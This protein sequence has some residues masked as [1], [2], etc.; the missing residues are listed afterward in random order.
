MPIAKHVDWREFLK[1][2]WLLWDTCAVINVI[3]YD[4]DELFSQLK[5]NGV[6]NVYIHP[7]QLELLATSDAK[8]AIKRADIL[9]KELELLPFTVNELKTAKNLQVAISTGSTSPPQAMD[10]YVGATLAN[11]NPEKMCLI[12]HNI[13]HFPS[14]Y[15]KQECYITLHNDRSASSLAILTFNKSSLA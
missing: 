14:P 10:L 7:I 1:D 12:T 13:K 9:D 11:N 4:E 5:E 6:K 2:K 8:E 15:F 3:K